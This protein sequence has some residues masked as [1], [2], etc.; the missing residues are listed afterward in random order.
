MLPT[1]CALRGRAAGRSQ[2]GCEGLGQSVV[3]F[4]V[5]RRR[6]GVRVD[7]V[8]HPPLGTARTSSSD[9]DMNAVVLNSG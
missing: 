3:R 2:S 5:G 1:G 4:P 6:G 7:G 9:I 8:Q